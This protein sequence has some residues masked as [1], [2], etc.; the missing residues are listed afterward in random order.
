MALPRAIIAATA[1]IL[2]AA[3]A[4]TQASTPYQLEPDASYMLGC[5]DPCT[6]PLTN[7]QHLGGS[8]MLT[9]VGSTPDSIDHYAVKR[10]DWT[11]IY[12]G[13]T[14]HVTG[15]GRYDIGGNPALKHRLR[16]NLSFDGGAAKAFDSGWIVRGSA[17]PQI[18]IVV[19]MH[20]MTCYDE[21]FRVRAAP[22]D[23]GT[24]Y[25]TSNPNST[26]TPATLYA[27]GSAAVSNN[28]FTLVAA[29]GPPNNVGT[30]FFGQGQQQAPFGAGILCVSSS[31][32]RLPGILIDA[33]GT[34]WQPL[35]LTQPPAAGVIVPG[36]NW[37][38]QFWYR[39]PAGGPG[40]FN[41]SQ[42]LAVT[43]Y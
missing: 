16:L 21:V 42:G 24:A 5:F 17:F 34:A 10:V 4:W 33:S 30:F 12:A 11:L 22:L 15:D 35:D 18:D 23:L 2:L 31:I 43:F 40:A 27:S 41:L 20:G 38:F 37:N 26:G 8:F 25:C 1:W 39:D 6:C 13:Q 7:A 28:E 36:S 29:N 14:I 9:L 32:V 19:S 3:Q